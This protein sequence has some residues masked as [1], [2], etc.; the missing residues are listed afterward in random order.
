MPERA[1]ELHPEASEEALAAYA[2]YLERSLI[3]ADRFWAELERAAQ[4]ILEG[5]GRWAPHIHQT[6][7]FVLT[8]QPAAFTADQWPTRRSRVAAE[9]L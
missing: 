8:S 4:L 7:R 9:A 1:L 2:W 5:P 3:S 6:R